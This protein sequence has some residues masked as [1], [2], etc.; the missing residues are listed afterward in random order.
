MEKAANHPSVS[1]LTGNVLVIGSAH[2]WR[3]IYKEEEAVEGQR[4]LQMWG[5][6][7]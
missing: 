1:P 6:T 4:V 3:Y 2:F 5:N 7:I